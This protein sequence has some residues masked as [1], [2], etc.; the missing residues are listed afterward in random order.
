MG[1]NNFFCRKSSQIL[2]YSPKL[3]PL[4]KDMEDIEGTRQKQEET[5]QRLEDVEAL[6]KAIQAKIR[7]TGKKRLNFMKNYFLEKVKLS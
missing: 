6:S 5:A 2:L 3:F 4:Q 1:G 7:D